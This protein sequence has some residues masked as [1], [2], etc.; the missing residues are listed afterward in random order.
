LAAAR[1]AHTGRCRPRRLCTPPGESQIRPPDRAVPAGTS[2]RTG[3]AR[4]TWA[5][6]TAASAWR[7]AWG[8]WAAPART[9]NRRLRCLYTVPAALGSLAQR[10]SCRPDTGTECRSRTRPR[11][12]PRSIG[13]SGSA[14]ASEWAGGRQARTRRSRS[15]RPCIHRVGSE[16]RDTAHREDKWDRSRTARRTVRSSIGRAGLALDSYSDSPGRLRC[17]PPDCCP[18]SRHTAP[19]NS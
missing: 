14:A 2:E 10:R 12:W 1:R 11:T 19:N 13:A 17:R 7:A 5:R 6:R 16:T 3:M 8:A 9:R 18:T 4:H 15:N